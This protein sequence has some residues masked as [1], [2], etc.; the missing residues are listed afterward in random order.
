[1]LFHIADRDSTITLCNKNNATCPTEC[2]DF[3]VYIYMHMYMRAFKQISWVLVCMLKYKN[4]INK[5]YYKL[6]SPFIPLKKV[7]ISMNIR[8]L[9][10]VYD[11]NDKWKLD[12]SIANTKYVDTISFHMNAFK[13]WANCLFKTGFTP[14][15][16]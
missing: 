16:V 14:S 11:T 9:I 8:L 3:C 7:N 5:T 12:L 10:E 2:F 4:T 15:I 1:M 6:F 13:L